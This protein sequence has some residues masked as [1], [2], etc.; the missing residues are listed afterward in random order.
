MFILTEPEVVYVNRYL[1]RMGSILF[2][3]ALKLESLAEVQTFLR[4]QLEKNQVYLAVKSSNCYKIY[5]QSTAEDVRRFVA[6]TKERA[7]RASVNANKRATTTESIT[8][9]PAVA[10]VRVLCYRGQTYKRSITATAS[11][12]HTPAGSKLRYRGV[13][14]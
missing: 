4:K 5:Q 11:V 6:N 13:A 7:R 3:P 2:Q 10:D 9:N 1:I 8:T 12:R 14:H